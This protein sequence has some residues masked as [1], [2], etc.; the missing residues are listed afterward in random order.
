MYEP[1]VETFGLK[2]IK[3]L[4]IYIA[5]LCCLDE[6]V[7]TYSYIVL[8][9]FLDQT[10]I[11]EYVVFYWESILKGSIRYKIYKII[12]QMCRSLARADARVDD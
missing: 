7:H 1:K 4:D 3:K 12:L 9:L 5:L 11:W 10:F 6:S 8:I 2:N